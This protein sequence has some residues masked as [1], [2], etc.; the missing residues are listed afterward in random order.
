MCG[1][2][3][4]ERGA[5]AAKLPDR[6]AEPVRVLLIQS[7]VIPGT[8]IRAALRD[9]GFEPRMFRADHEPAVSAALPRGGYDVILLHT[10]STGIT[11]AT[12]HRMMREHGARIPV[13]ELGDLAD[14]ASAIRA[15]LAHVRN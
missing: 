12:L 4:F 7:W 5:F 8:A 11:R 14:L 6:M 9:G 2:A 1:C 10:P 3:S 13:L 15:A